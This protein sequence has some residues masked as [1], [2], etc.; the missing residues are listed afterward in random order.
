MLAMFAMFAISP[1]ALL[2]SSLVGLFP[3][4]VLGQDNDIPFSAC[5]LIGAYYPPPT[6]SASPGAFSQLQAKFTETFDKLIED[7]GSEDYGPITPNTTSF[8]IVLF[9][10]AESMKDDPVL[11]EYHFT[12]PEDEARTGTNLTASTKVPVGDV[13]MVFTVYAWLVGMGEK[14]ETPITEFLPELADVQGGLSV[15]W[16]EVTIGSLAGQMSGLSRLSFFD[17]FAEQ[18]PVFLPDTTPVVSHAAFQLLAFAVERS[19]KGDGGGDWKSFLEDAVFDPLNMTSTALLE[20]GMDDVFAIEGLNTSRIGEPAA[21]GLVTSIEDL[22][23]AGHSMLSSSLLPDAVTRRWLHPNM[24]TSNL[25]NGVGRPWEV[26]RAGSSA[27]SP[28]LDVL[29]KS[30]SIGKYASY[31]GLTVD[32]DAGFAIVAHDSSVED[33]TLDLNVYADIASES[34]GYLQEFAAK[35]LASRFTGNYKGGGGD[36]DYHAQLNV[37][38]S[39]PGL[40]VQKLSAGGKDLRAEAAGKLGVALPDLDFRVYPS[41]ARDEAAGRQQFVAVFQD[42]GAPVDMGTPTCVTWQEVGAVLGD[43]YNLVFTLDG[44]G[45]STG[46]ELPRDN[47]SLRKL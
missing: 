44:D 4:L 21:L 16:D 46:F 45:M 14:W 33:G 23:R 36:D 11:F 28:V 47:V 32:F 5:P 20:H 26:Y 38:G 6:I 19:V 24:D 31:F 17:T 39:G 35:E 30:G 29:T 13:T 10:G 41:N 43:G 9:S 34:L 22:A 1:I 37:T 7:G 25:R 40:E 2:A 8:S 15:R 12:S 27:I 3:I 42:K 18:R